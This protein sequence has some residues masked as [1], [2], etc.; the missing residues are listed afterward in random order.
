[1]GKVLA[2]AVAA[3]ILL[4]VVAGGCVA[5]VGGSAGSAAGLAG[6]TGPSGPVGSG[7]LGSG[8]AVPAGWAAT[9]QAAA[10]TCPGLGWGVL[11]AIGRLASDSGRQ[12]GPG[13]ASGTGP[14]G[15]VG[16][17]QIPATAEVAQL[18]AGPGGAVPPTPYDPVDA[19]YTAAAVLC[20][21][22]AG[23]T[24]HLTGALA[25][26]DPSPT[27]PATVEVLATALEADPAVPS[28]AATALT[29]AAGELGTPYLWGGESP[30]GY[31]CSGLV[32]AAYRAAGVT[33][34]RVAQDQ[35][36]AGPVL[37]DG[38]PVAPGDLLFYGASTTLVTHVGIYVGDGEM[39]DAPHTGAV[40]RV[41]GA[42]WPD[43]VGATRPG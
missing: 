40:V 28:D 9:E 38:I 27:F 37:A 16:P 11:G 6:L 25:S 29:F 42:D 4:A 31:D 19:V 43:L 32:Q 17:M 34:P 7:G 18:T 10:A 22:G 20:R 2:G 26:W 39:I 3:V 33:L 24:D 35:Y 5:A 14:D 1:M 12:G 21:N 23:S 41:E 30:A 8:P 36:D 13:V 15:G